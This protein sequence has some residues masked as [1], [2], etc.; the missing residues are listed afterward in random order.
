MINTVAEG[1]PPAAGGTT[2]VLKAAV[3]I[4]VSTS[5]LRSIWTDKIIIIM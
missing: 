5:T 2:T 4:V 3:V 1:M